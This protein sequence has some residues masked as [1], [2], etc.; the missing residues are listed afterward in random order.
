MEHS[1]M[2]VSCQLDL[3]VMVLTK[4]SESEKVMIKSKNPVRVKAVNVK[5]NARTNN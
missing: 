5:R 3:L 2:R 4:T 1:D